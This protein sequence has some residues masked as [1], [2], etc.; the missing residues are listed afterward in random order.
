LLATAFETVTMAADEASLI[1][2]AGRL[3]PDVAI[4]DLLLSKGGGLGWLGAVRQRCPGLKV[5]VLGA[6]E[7][8]AM[9]RAA[10]EAGVDAFVLRE[11]IATD[12]LPAVSRVWGV[13]G[14]SLR[15][16]R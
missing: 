15:G 13:P 12:L 9:R 2:G 16:Q 6:N 3:R 8:Q 5:I 1:E 11:R 4:V 14:G 10:I 7:D